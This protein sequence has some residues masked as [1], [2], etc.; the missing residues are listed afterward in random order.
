METASLDLSS[1]VLGN[2]ANLFCLRLRVNCKINER[3]KT[4]SKLLQLEKYEGSIQ[5]FRCYMSFFI[6][7]Q[8]KF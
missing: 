2:T 5:L 4:A 7:L 1:D 6:K 8:G 3:C